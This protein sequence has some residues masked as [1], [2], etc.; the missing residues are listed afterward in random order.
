M[1]Q[2]YLKQLFT[3]LLL[4]CTT[5]AFAHDFEVDGIYYNVLSEEDK[6]VEVTYKGSSNS[7]Y[8]NEYTGSVVIPETVTKSEFITTV[9]GTFDAWTST[10][11]GNG[12]TTSQTSYTLNVEAGQILKF[13]WSVSSESNCDWLTITLDGTEI[14]KKSGTDSSSYEKTFDIAGTH[15]LVVKYSK[16]GSVDNGDDEGKIY[17]ITLNTA[18]G[19]N[20]VV[21]SVTFIGDYAFYNCSGLTSIDI[22]NNVTAI[23]EFA[24]FCSGLTSIEIPNSVTSIGYAAFSSCKGLT[25]IEIPNSLTSIGDYAFNDCSGLKSVVI[26]NSVTS[27]GNYAFNNCD[28]LKSIVIPNSVISIGN[29][30]FNDCTG[31]K[32]VVIPNSVTSIG[33]KAFAYCT[34]LTSVEFNAENC[35]Y[36]GSDFY[37]VFSDCTALSKVTIGEKVKNIPDYAFAYCSGLTSVVI[38]NSVTSIGRSAFRD[39]DRLTSVVIGNSVTTIGD[40]AF[41]DCTGLTSIEIPNSVTSIGYEAFRGC[42]D[43]TG[44]LVIPN[45][46]TRIG[47]YAFR[48]CDSL[49]NVV[50][51]NSVTSI[52]SSVFYYCTGLKSVVI[53]NSVTSIGTYAFYN[54]RSL[55]SIEIP[56]SVTS[57]GAYAFES[58][59]RLTSIEIPAS[60]TRIGDNAFRGC[61]GL[62]SITSLIPAEDLFS[63]N[64]NVLDKTTCTLYVPY[65]AK[66]TYA[67]TEGWNEFANIVELDPSEITITINQYGCATYCSP[68]ALDFSEIEGLKAYA[69]TGYNKA[70][71]VVTLTRLQTAEAG[72][73]LFLKGEPGEYVVPIIEYSN[74]YSL[75]MLVGTLEQTTVNSTEDEMSNYKFTVAELDEAPMFYPFEDNTTFSAGKA[76]LQIPTAWLPATAQKSVSIRFDE[77]ETTDVDELKGENG[78]LKG[79]SGEVQAIY[80]LQGR[81]VE[82]PTSGI[83]I[84]DGKKVLI[85]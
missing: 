57:I 83:Y 32:S 22:P 13:D 63:I 58:C 8:S 11:K 2:N 45:S 17:N 54:C 43:L 19:T 42:S 52:G 41:R 33:D 14:V 66:E 76:Y 82:N 44:E 10:N 18:I 4:L 6:T 77:G 78:K 79:E 49:T 75:N 46:V 34:G 47:T 1:K 5:V 68:F 72:V 73:G 26:P 56:A 64:S 80:D 74:D 85:K 48:D 31:L 29:D 40:W 7:E 59:Y 16:D 28:V 30:A 53:P 55:T 65:G 3:A 25:S 35:T 61:T 71:Q 23:G 38:P 84:I 12:G 37:P 27:I 51:G 62:T 50:I 20:D 39:C 24:F 67:A 21:Y 15:T 70:T 81:V 36:M 9:L 60:V 69:A